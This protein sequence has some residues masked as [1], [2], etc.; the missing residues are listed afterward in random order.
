MNNK[1]CSIS[2]LPSITSFSW[3]SMSQAGIHKLLQASSIEF[4]IGFL[5]EESKEQSSRKCC[6]DSSPFLHNVHIGSTLFWLNDALNICIHILTI[7]E[8]PFDK[9]PQGK[10][11]SSILAHRSRRLIR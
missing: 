2:T 4:M 10:E 8:A 11:K 7:Y 5:I 9:I 6:S 3:V 1:I